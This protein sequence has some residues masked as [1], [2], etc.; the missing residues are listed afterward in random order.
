MAAHRTGRTIACDSCGEPVYLPRCRLEKGARFC[1]NHCRASAYSGRLNPLS[2][3]GL[4]WDKDGGRWLVC[5]RDRTTMSYARVKYESFKSALEAANRF[6]PSYPT[7]E[8]RV[9][10]KRKR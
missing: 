2:N 8:L 5:C 4:C 1:S 3:D 6:A 7:L 10:E 9:V